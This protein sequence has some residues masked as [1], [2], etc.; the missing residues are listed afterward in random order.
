[1][2]ISAEI[3]GNSFKMSYT[4]KRAVVELLRAGSG[5]AVK[6]SDAVMQCW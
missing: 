2:F 3:E 1:M 4:V 5:A 6:R